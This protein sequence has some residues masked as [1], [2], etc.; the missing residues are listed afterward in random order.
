L[1]DQ[2]YKQ[3]KS[4]GGGYNGLALEGRCLQKSEDLFPGEAVTGYLLPILKEGEGHI[5]KRIE[6]STTGWVEIDEIDQGFS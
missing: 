5:E 4:P 1:L 6:N 2:T 3:L